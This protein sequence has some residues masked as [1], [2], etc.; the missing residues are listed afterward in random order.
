MKIVF[1]VP[2][3][4]AEIAVAERG[5]ILNRLTGAG[6]K[7]AAHAEGMLLIDRHERIVRILRQKLPDRLAEI[8]DMQT[9]RS[10]GASRALLLINSSWCR[11]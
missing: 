4:K 9:A 1:P 6:N 10:D 11:R 5:Q 7:I 2:D 8:S 3:G